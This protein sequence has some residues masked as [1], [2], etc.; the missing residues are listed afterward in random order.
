MYKALIIFFM[1]TNIVSAQCIREDKVIHAT[2]VYLLSASTTS[3][4]YNRTKS[5]KK[6]MVYGFILPM[7]A[8]VAKE[9]RDIKHGDPDV[10]D[11]LANTV[12]ASLGVITIRI[13]L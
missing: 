7:I 9:I 2:S 4:V 1:I 5:K 13:T 11:V 3:L 10:N 6:A 8:G 12:G